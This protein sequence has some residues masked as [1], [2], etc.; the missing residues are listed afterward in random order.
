MA[1][2]EIADLTPAEYESIRKLVYDR[3]GIDL[4]DKKMQLVRSRL[5]KRVREL[6][7]ETFGE[8]FQHARND[9]SGQELTRLLDAIST[10]TTHLFREHRH[11]EF[12][13]E[14]LREW[15]GAAGRGGA[16]IRIWSAG[17]SSGDEPYSISMTA[18]EALGGNPKAVKILATDLSTRMLAK[19]QCG[20]FEAPR[21]ANVPPAMKAKYLAQ[22]SGHG[23]TVYEAAPAIRALI[24][25]GA[26]NLM[27]EKFPFRNPFDVIFCRNVMIYFDRR[28]QEGLVRRFAGVLRSGGYLLIGHS[29]SLNNITQPLRYV[30]PTIY[31]K[32]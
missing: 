26:F 25:F 19:A 4:G 28:T 24:T 11:F 18:L 13:A 9:A 7:F 31:Q 15:H 6:E 3:S 10:N 5:A 12:L 2:N 32:P 29:E 8:Y 17:C 23:E 27:T 14:R 30:Q 16:P 20:L 1:V 22:R 21:V